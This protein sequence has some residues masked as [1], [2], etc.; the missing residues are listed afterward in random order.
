MKTIRLF[1]AVFLLT[2]LCSL[3]TLQAQTNLL[4]NPGFETVTDGVP[5]GWTLSP[6]GDTRVT[7]SV[8]SDT[9]Y[10]GSKSIKIATIST[11][12]KTGY[13]NQYIAAI[14]GKKYDLSLWARVDYVATG[15]HVYFEYQ[16]ADANGNL[17]ETIAGTEYAYT[18]NQ[19]GNIA[20]QTTEAPTG[21]SYLLFQIRTSRGINAHFDKA[22]VTEVGAV[23]KQ[24]QTITG[25]NNMD[26]TV[27]DA[28]F[29]LSATATSGL[30]VSY[31]SSNTAV[32]TISGNTVHI[33]GAGTTTITAS[34]AGNDTYN[35]ATPVTATLTVNAASTSKNL[36]SNPGFENVTDGVPDGWTLEDPSNGAG[37]VTFESVTSPVYEGIKSL[38]ITCTDYLDVP[39]YQYIPVTPGKKYNMSAW[40]NVES[41][42]VDYGFYAWLRYS[43]VNA[44]GKT[45]NDGS[46]GGDTQYNGTFTKNTWQE[47]Q[48][49]AV[50]APSSAVYLKMELVTAYHIVAYFDNVSVTEVVAAGINNIRTQLP[51][52]IQNGNIIVTTQS[53][54]PVEVYNALG[55][56]LKSQTAN[57]TETT[58]TNL[59]KGQVLIV[60]SG[61]AVA[62]VIL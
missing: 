29:N 48:A 1:F 13:V 15:A 50:E 20:V 30:A 35:A 43:F 21:A 40:F 38:K 52:R 53:G 6:I 37:T 58:L 27:G 41:F 31:S 60:R 61:N 19:W 10:E 11:S 47:L 18:L 39:V 59:P 25:L 36:V 28:D 56:K 12:S 17:L 4:T 16:F 62:K 57:S 49:K 2:T 3:T 42:E 26:K 44:E 55:L 33:V 23:S 34:Q 8:V 51:L 45:I 14:P 54:S 22:S 46:N 5:D 7:F 24:D 9:I 32:A